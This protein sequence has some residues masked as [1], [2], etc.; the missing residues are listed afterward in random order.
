M[1]EQNNEEY[2]LSHAR[3]FTIHAETGG[4]K[5]GK[6]MTK[7]KKKKKKNGADGLVLSSAG[8]D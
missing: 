2:L 7:K 1:E 3:G 5:K 8:F 4:L 6:K